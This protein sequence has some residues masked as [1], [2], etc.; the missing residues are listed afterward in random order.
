MHA[1]A[2]STSRMKISHPRNGVPS[3]KKV[4]C[5]RVCMWTLMRCM[6]GQVYPN[7][8]YAIDLFPHNHYVDY[9]KIIN[10]AIIPVI[11]RCSLLRAYFL[12]SA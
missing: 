2:K 3:K 11:K 9:P 8:Y 10:F 5:V 1:G 7:F 6:H 4:V 12:L